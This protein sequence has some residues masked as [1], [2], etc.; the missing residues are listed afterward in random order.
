MN[1]L[2]ITKEY[3]K[4]KVFKNQDRFHIQN[5]DAT[6]ERLVS[7]ETLHDYYQAKYVDMKP[8]PEPVAPMPT[9]NEVSDQRYL[10]AFGGDFHFRI[11]NDSDPVKIEHVMDITETEEIDGLNICA[12]IY[13]HTFKTQYTKMNRMWIGTLLIFLTP[14]IYRGFWEDGPIF[15]SG[16]HILI[17]VALSQVKW[18]LMMI[19]FFM[20]QNLNSL[21]F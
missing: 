10:R 20:L 6:Y 21:M 9:L 1:K 7:L 13:F 4:L 15:Q 19:N 12:E 5:Y 17:A 2:S 18:P 11:P 8:L 14:Y 16:E 3:F